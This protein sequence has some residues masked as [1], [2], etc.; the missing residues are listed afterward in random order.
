M[1]DSLMSFSETFVMLTLSRTLAL[2][3]AAGLIASGCKEKSESQ[4]LSAPGL[5]SQPISQRPDGASPAPVSA[6]ART[7]LDHVN[8]AL[9]K[10]DLESATVGLINLGRSGP[11]LSDAERV[12]YLSSMR[13]LQAQL[14]EAAARN[15]PK[16]NEMIQLLK[17]SRGKY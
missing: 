9:K 12:A 7:T 4:P 16:A 3:L 1:A 17:A 8:S 2:A 5:E 13:S 14:A 6:N 11:P 15:D 10:H